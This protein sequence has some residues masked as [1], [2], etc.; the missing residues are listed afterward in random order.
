M[1]RLVPTYRS[2]HISR[3][4]PSLQARCTLFSASASASENFLQH[5]SDG[6]SAQGIDFDGLF[7]SCNRVHGAKLLHALVVVSGKAQSVFFSGKLVNVYAYLGDVSFARRTFDHIPNKDVYTWNSM[8]SAYVRTGHFR[9]AVD[10][11]YRFFLTS[12]LQPDFYTFAP[13]LKACKNPLDGMR[14]H[15]VVLKFGFEWDVFVTASLVH[16]YTRF[17]AFSYA[18]KLFDDMPVRDMGCW[19]AMISGYCQN[20]NAAEALDVLNEMRLEGVIMDPVTIVSILPICAQSDDILNGMLIH[21]YAIKRGLEFDLFVS[22][23]L[24]NMYAK[25]VK[26]ANAQKVFDNMV[27]RDVVSW[28]SIIAAYEQNDYPDRALALFYMQ[29]TGISPDHLTLV[30]LSSIVAQLGG[31]RSAKSVHGFVMRRGWIQKDVISGNS[32]VDMYG[33]LGDINSARAVFDAQPVKDVVSWNTLI[34]GYAQN[35][36]ASEAIEAFDLMQ[37]YKEVAPNQATWVGILPAYS[38]VGALR[39]GMRVHGLSI[40]TSLYFDI[41]VG[42]CLIDMYGKCGELDDAMTFFYEVPKMNSVPWN[43]II[44]CLGI[45]G[46]AEKAIKLFR[47]MREEGVKPDHITFVS[48][49]SACSHSGLVEEGQWCFNVMKE[50]YGIEPILKHYG[51]MVDMFGRAGLLEMAYNFIKNMPIKPDASVWGALLGACRIHGNVDLGAIASERLFEVDSENVGY[52]VLLSNIYANIQKWEGVDKVRTQARDMGLR[53]TPGWSSIEAN[54]KVD[55]FYTGNQSHPKCE[56][57]YKE[58]RSLNAKMKSLGYVPDYSFVLQDVED[59]EK[60][61]ILMSHSERLAIAFGVLNTPP[62]TPIRI[63]KN[64]RVCGD[65]HN[66]TKYI[67]KITER[68][69]VV[70]DSNRF[71]H[72]IDG[73]CSCGDYW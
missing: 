37:E 7:K 40:K 54:N 33:K 71:H 58:L 31:S 50:E 17:G 14:I 51:C 15:C 48:L 38:S 3:S 29:L 46:H 66:A 64:L 11:F 42:T 5:T 69:I 68:E 27:V 20:G 61:H 22:N 24:I 12:G 26:L 8:V 59:D 13:V 49:L 16:M 73:V 60:E 44:S 23:A 70:R 43:A 32:V 72:F 1:F 25:F 56:E 9:E 55:I 6:G 62:K 35:G 41:F 10:C 34:T 53:K 52:Y 39:Q 30:S 21:V 67:S 45:H 57:I 47:V 19:N 63:F 65:C 18:R 28:N 36:L 2:R 4:L